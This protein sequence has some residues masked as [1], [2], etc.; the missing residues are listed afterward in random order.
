MIHDVSKSIAIVVAEQARREGVARV[1]ENVDFISGWRRCFG[2]QNTSI[3]S[4][5]VKKA[6]DVVYH[7][8]CFVKNALL[9]HHLYD[10]VRRL[11]QRCCFNRVYFDWC[12]AHVVMSESLKA[13]CYSMSRKCM[14]F[15]VNKVVGVGEYVSD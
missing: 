12:Q 1:G 11:L 13:E 5:L 14:H 7:L 9:C 6:R 10:G 8:I 15:I 2:H 4:G 3:I